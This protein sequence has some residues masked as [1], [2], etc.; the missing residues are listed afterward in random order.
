MPSQR[1][2]KDRLLH[3]VKVSNHEGKKGGASSPFEGKNDPTGGKKKKK[4]N[5][6]EWEKGGRST[7]LRL[8]RK[9][10]KKKICLTGREPRTTRVRKKRKKRP[11]KLPSYLLE[12]HMLKDE[13]VERIGKKKHPGRMES[14]S[15]V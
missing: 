7:F 12:T 15:A 10:K 5:S 4:K 1:P 3:R 8:M 2:G 14:F 6:Q 9:K 11:L 13:E